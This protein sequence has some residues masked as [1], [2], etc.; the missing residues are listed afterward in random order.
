MPDGVNAPLVYGLYDVDGPSGAVMLNLPIGPCSAF[1]DDVDELCEIDVLF[2]AAPAPW[3]GR[4]EYD[5]AGRLEAVGAPP[6]C[7]GVKGYAV[8]VVVPLRGVAVLVKAHG[9]SPPLCSG[10]DWA[11]TD[12]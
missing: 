10:P 1:N 3:R 4:P 6:I 7:E 11:D 5:R 9:L 8:A 12:G 2:V